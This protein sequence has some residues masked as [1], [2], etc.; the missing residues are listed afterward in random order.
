MNVVHKDNVATKVGYIITVLSLGYGSLILL[1]Y[2][3]SLGW[4]P[5]G[6]AILGLAAIG[7]IMWGYSKLGRL[8]LSVGP[9]AL[10]SFFHAVLVEGGDSMIPSIYLAQV[11]LA[12]S[13]CLVFDLSD[14]LML[15]IAGMV[16]ISV[17]CLQAFL[18]E[19]IEPIHGGQELIA[20][21]W[22]GA[23]NYLI[24]V[25][26]I[27]FSLYFYL[28]E[29]SIGEARSVA[30]AAELRAYQDRLLSDNQNLYAE[31]LEMSMLNE[32][33]EKKIYQ[34]TERLR[35]QNKQLAEHSY[36][37]SHLLRAPLCRLRGLMNLLS[38]DGL[39]VD[40]Q[41]E[42]ML[43][44]QGA[45]EEMDDLTVRISQLL[46]QNDLY[47]KYQLNFKQLQEIINSKN[48]DKALARHWN[49]EINQPTS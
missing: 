2:R 21:T 33:L 20:N 32:I 16:S 28:R 22:I 48:R 12:M 40:D 37:N 13:V 3:S 44:M 36:I 47:Q 46:E 24:S 11:G 38:E 1:V 26:L 8:M 5:F 35:S 25:C 39:R 43:L 34:R 10:C 23:V 41:K 30:L 29:M 42:I 18:N 4:L 7:L 31:Q 49:E 45:I 6:A 27:V 19:R 15:G 14:R 17:L 9:L